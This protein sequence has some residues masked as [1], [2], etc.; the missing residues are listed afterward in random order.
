MLPDVSG[1][2]RRTLFGFPGEP[3]FLMAASATTFE[4]INHEPA[5]YG[6][7]HNADL[8]GPTFIPAATFAKV[9]S[10]WLL[11]TFKR[12]QGSRQDVRGLQ[13]LL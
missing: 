10:N 5:F 1:Y 13:I 6:A 8:A 12:R 9:A 4:A 3:D 2:R 7:R 11:W